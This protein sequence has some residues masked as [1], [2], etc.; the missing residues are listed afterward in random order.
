LSIVFFKN[1]NKDIYEKER[2]REREFRT[3]IEKTNKQ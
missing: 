1:K 3:A 2:E